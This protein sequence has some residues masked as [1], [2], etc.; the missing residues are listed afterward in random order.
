VVWFDEDGNPVCNVDLAKYGLTM[1]EIDLPQNVKDE[2]L[3]RA[4]PNVEEVPLTGSESPSRDVS[5]AETPCATEQS[6]PPS[7]PWLYA[8]ILSAL[9]AGVALWLIRKKR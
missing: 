8:V 9:C 3:R 6:P 7:R 5:T 1:P 4:R 2:I